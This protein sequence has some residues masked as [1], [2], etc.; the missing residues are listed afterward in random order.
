M[1]APLRTPGEPFNAEEDSNGY[2]DIFIFYLNWPHEE[3]VRGSLLIFTDATD[4]NVFAQSIGSIRQSSYA[5]HLS[6]NDSNEIITFVKE[7]EE[8]GSK[9]NT[10]SF[11]AFNGKTAVPKHFLPDFGYSAI[12]ASRGK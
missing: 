11:Q 10:A 2:S 7:S 8:L 6:Q 5:E 1:A 9:F 12:F 4:R 3:A